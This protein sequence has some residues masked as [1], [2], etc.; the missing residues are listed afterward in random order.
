MKIKSL[1]LKNFKRFTDL[2]LQDIPDNSKL[3]LLIGSNGSGKSSVFD[4]FEAINK[5]LKS[6]DDI[7]DEVYYKKNNTES[8]I[9]NFYADNYEG[10]QFISSHGSYI[11][12]RGNNTFYGRSAVRYSP[13]IERTVI[14]VPI[15]I[16]DDADRPGYYI[17]RDNRFENDIDLLLS[18]IV[19]K[20]FSDLN[21]ITNGKIDEV[22]K[23][24]QRLNESLSNIFRSNN[25][26]QLEL[27]NFQSP[28]DGKP[29]QLIFRKGDVEINYDLLSAGEKEII[30][31]L[32][33]LYARATHFTNTIYFFDEIDAH[34]NT[35]L[36]YALLKELIE[37]W[38]PDNCQFWTASHSLGFIQYAKESDHAS[39]FDF[40]DFDF[41]YPKILSPEPKDNPDLYDIA[42]DKNF[43]SKL[44]TGF[45]IY[46]VENTD[47]VYYSF[48]NL[49]KTIF[50]PEK[51]RNA[52]YY[53]VKNGEYNGIIDRDYLSDDDII[54]IEKYYP[55]LKILKYYSIENYL[56]HPDNLEEYKREKKSPFDKEFYEEQIRIAKNKVIPELTIKIA[57]IRNSYPFFDDPKYD[58]KNNTN[59][60]R[61]KN[62]EE[63]FTNTALVVG[64]LNSNDFESFYKSFS[65]KDYGKH[66]PERNN[67]PSE[68]AQTSW[69]KKQ[70][71]L[72]IK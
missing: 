60:L 35:K 17:D 11:S 70:I 65:M 48:S 22:K 50:V 69:F 72:I 5:V 2:T 16:A 18:E 59:R 38:I 13:R 9:I 41:D 19:K 40:D 66:L 71:E 61:F 1:Q 68:L 4:A 30:N 15:K 51:G 29:A 31:L 23:F 14:G 54:E 62:K 24:M 10:K 49:V 37:N 8:Y 56:Y 27:I 7:D 34:L 36:Q 20:V 44:F 3:V 52:V 45:D 55:S 21:N 33:N 47:Q 53:K 26:S 58:S 12:N 67:P 57:T 46:F 64:Y 6:V 32:I 63:N 39:I 42:I 43:L 25:Y 28:A